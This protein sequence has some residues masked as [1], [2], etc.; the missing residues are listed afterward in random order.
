MRTCPDMAAMPMM[1]D[2]PTGTSM[3]GMRKALVWLGDTVSGFGAA[4]LVYVV[5]GSLLG[6]AL[7]VPYEAHQGCWPTML[8]TVAVYC[9][10]ALA[11]AFWFGTIQLPSMFAFEPVRAYWAL[12]GS[13]DALI[14]DGGLG[15]RT[16]IVVMLVVVG[17]FAWRTRS[18]FVG[19]A[20]ALALIGEFIVAAKI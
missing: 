4:F 17:F 7:A 8:S 18:A 1:L 16:S 10:D 14:D 6:R 15:I 3:T 13:K 19:W 5:L 2:E 11:G 20:L 12:T 9:E